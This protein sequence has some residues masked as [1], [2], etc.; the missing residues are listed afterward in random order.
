MLNEL[1]DGEDIENVDEGVIYKKAAENIDKLSRIELYEVL[2]RLPWQAQVKLMKKRCDDAK[3][4]L[5]CEAYEIALKGDPSAPA[6][7]PKNLGL[8]RM[9]MEGNELV[10]ELLE[11]LGEI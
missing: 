4:E 2:R 7:T 3:D 5:A 1:F 9:A 11:E 8:R 6:G 10:R